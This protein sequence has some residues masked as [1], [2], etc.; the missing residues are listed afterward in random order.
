MLLKYYVK[1]VYAHN[2]LDPSYV[3]IAHF[4]DTTKKPNSTVSVYFH[5]DIQLY[6][7]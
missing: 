5:I 6:T 4:S 3:K 7:I 1:A 2:D